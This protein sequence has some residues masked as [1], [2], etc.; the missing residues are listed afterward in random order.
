MV[1]NNPSQAT[2]KGFLLLLLIEAIINTTLSFKH[3]VTIGCI[4]SLFVSNSQHC[5]IWYR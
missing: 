1:K 2:W 5:S 3:L 4:L